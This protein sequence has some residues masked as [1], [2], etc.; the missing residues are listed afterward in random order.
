MHR[1]NVRVTKHYTKIN[2][3]QINKYYVIIYFPGH[4]RKKQQDKIVCFISKLE[5]GENI[6]K[7]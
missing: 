5:K 6:G 4:Y 2:N 3:K 1:N 7:E